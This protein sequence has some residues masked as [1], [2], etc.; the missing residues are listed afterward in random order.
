MTDFPDNPNFVF[1]CTLEEETIDPEAK[2]LTDD[3]K[4][5]KCGASLDYCEDEGYKSWWECSKCG[6][7]ENVKEW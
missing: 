6:N 5:D 7:I 3:P 1:K 2:Y 4:C